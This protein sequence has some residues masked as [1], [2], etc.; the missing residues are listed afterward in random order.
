MLKWTGTNRIEVGCDWFD[1]GAVFTSL[2]LKENIGGRFPTGLIKLKSKNSDT[3]REWILNKTSIELTLGTIDSGP[4]LN[5][6]GIISEKQYFNGFATLGFD[7]VPSSDFY[8]KKNIVTWKQPIDDVIK[9][10][11]KKKVDI[12]TQTDLPSGLEFIQASEYDCD[13]LGN[14]CT[15]YKKD[16]IFALGLDGLLIKDLIGID[17]T[18]NKEPYWTITGKGDTASDVDGDGIGVDRPWLTYDKK[19][20]MEPEDNTVSSYFNSKFF[21]NKYR[22][23]DKKLAVLRENFLNNQKIYNSM[24]YG[25][26]DLVKSDIFATTYRLGDVVYY[27]RPGEEEQVLPWGIYL[28]SGIKYEISSEPDENSGVAPFSQIYTLHSLQEK[29]ATLP[30]VGKDPTDS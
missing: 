16:T 23:V 3:F 12:R 17:S 19:L 4:V 8:K 5:I 7:C 9:A 22:L 20:Y 26:I 27:E 21:D 24:M 30:G 10:L 18:G 11:W 15:S 29:G 25:Q 28:I 2:E 14:L 1:T 6:F 13:F